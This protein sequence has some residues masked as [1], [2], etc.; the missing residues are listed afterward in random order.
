MQQQGKEWS[1]GEE[2]GVAENV[3]TANVVVTENVVTANVVVTENVVTANVLI[4]TVTVEVTL[5]IE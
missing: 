2:E 4:V 3:V 1:N 5:R